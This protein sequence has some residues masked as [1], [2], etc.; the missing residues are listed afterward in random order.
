MKPT[1]PTERA[2]D[3]CHGGSLDGAGGGLAGGGKGRSWGAVKGFP[4]LHLPAA[5]GGGKAMTPHINS[6]QFFRHAVEIARANLPYCDGD[7]E[8]AARSALQEAHANLGQREFF[9]AIDAL[10][11]DEE[12]RRKIVAELSD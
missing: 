2:L 9:A 8:R 6:D 4:A 5:G 12:L 3:L 7:K 10:G 11:G 1:L